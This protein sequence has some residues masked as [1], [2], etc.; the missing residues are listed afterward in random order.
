MDR[1][2]VITDLSLTHWHV[3]S[4]CRASQG[5]TMDLIRTASSK[6]RVFMDVTV[7]LPPQGAQAQ[8]TEETA[9][10]A[11]ACTGQLQ[12]HEQTGMPA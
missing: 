1:H 8:G 2:Q 9:G 6:R 3:A 7:S 4:V 12:R 5:K 11:R 10:A